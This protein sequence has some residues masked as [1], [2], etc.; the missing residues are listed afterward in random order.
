MRDTMSAQSRTPGVRG[1][2]EASVRGF[3]LGTVPAEQLADEAGGAVETV[4][5]R[6]RRV[7]IVDLPE[8]DRLTVTA[9]MLVRVCDA[10]LAG[11]L[12][13]TALETV[14]FAIVASNR[15]GWREDD[16]IV[17]RVLYDWASPEVT[18]ELTPA[19]VRMFREWL[20][21]EAMPPS[22][23]EMTPDSMSGLGLLRRTTK[24]HAAG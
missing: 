18:W 5:E 7:Y 4:S 13:A 6:A 3:L 16:E 1:L 20:T 11:A 10:F 19:S 12:P 21:G 24:V 17:G 8:G 23:P 15:L 22:E 14:A 2:K 9:P